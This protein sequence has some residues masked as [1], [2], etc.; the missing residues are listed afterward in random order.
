MS[1]HDRGNLLPLGGCRQPHAGLQQ[2]PNSG[3]AADPG[4]DEDDSR[5]Q[6]LIVE[7]LDKFWPARHPQR[8]GSVARAAVRRAMGRTAVRAAAIAHCAPAAATLATRS[9]G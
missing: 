3:I 4:K 2:L 1:F 7:Q 5:Q 8:T 9:A 6:L